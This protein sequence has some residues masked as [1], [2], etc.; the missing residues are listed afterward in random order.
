M[1]NK[2][3]NIFFSAFWFIQALA[4]VFTSYRPHYTITVLLMLMVS[5]DNLNHMLNRYNK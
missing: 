1:K 3:W 5:L 4:I 2:I